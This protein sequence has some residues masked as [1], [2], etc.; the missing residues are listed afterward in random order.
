MNYVCR[1]GYGISVSHQNKRI[2]LNMSL[3]FFLNMLCLQH[4][5]TFEGSKQASKSLLKTTHKLPVFIS[6]ELL[7]FP[8]HSIRHNEVIYINY[9]NILYTKESFENNTVFMFKNGEKLVS[10]QSFN[11]IKLQLLKTEKLLENRKFHQLK[12]FTMMA[13]Q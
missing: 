8:T 6:D 1:S 3:Q 12:V 7:V 5:T 11:K 9:S 13:K 4:F 2:D 10:K